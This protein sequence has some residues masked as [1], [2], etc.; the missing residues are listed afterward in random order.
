MSV[1]KDKAVFTHECDFCGSTVESLKVYD[2][3]GVFWWLE[4][5]NGS[6]SDYLAIWCGDCGPKHRK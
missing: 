2:E 4:G 1:V 6:G 3:W 5:L